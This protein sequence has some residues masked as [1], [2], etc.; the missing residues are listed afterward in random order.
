MHCFV[1]DSFQDI[2]CTHSM[3]FMPII[4]TRRH[5]CSTTLYWTYYYWTLLG[6]SENR[7]VLGAHAQNTGQETL[8]AS[9][10]TIISI[11]TMRRVPEREPSMT[12]GDHP[13][14]LLTCTLSHHTTRK[15]GNPDITN[16]ARNYDTSHLHCR[17][18]Y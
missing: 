9:N 16:K 5:F 17:Y 3:E 7:P 8:K 10:R 4:Y 12:Y 6:S 2:F 18:P 13:Q 14:R 1:C 11:T 15:K